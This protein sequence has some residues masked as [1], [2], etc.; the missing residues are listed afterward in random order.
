MACYLG[1]SPIAPFDNGNQSSIILKELAS[2][3]TKAQEA[4]R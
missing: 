2:A 1:T 3:I 4:T